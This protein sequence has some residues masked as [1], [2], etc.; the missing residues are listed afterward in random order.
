M[1]SDPVV[2]AIPVQLIAGD[3]LAPSQVNETSIAA[4]GCHGV[5]SVISG[6]SFPALTVSGIGTVVAIAIVS[7]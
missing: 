5:V 4:S 1:A 2:G 3:E 7:V 6:K